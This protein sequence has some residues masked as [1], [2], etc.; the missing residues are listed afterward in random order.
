MPD[1]DVSKVPFVIVSV[2]VPQLNADPS[3]QPP[4]APLKSTGP[5]NATPLV[6]TVLPVVVALNVVVPVYVRVKF[7]A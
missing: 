2:L 7:V 6:V 1:D 4:P 5:P 3:V